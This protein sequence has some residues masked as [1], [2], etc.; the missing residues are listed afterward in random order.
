MEFTEVCMRRRSVRSYENR[1]I[2]R[3]DLLD[4]LEAGMYAPSAVNLQ[5]WHFVVLQSEEHLLRLRELMTSVSRSMQ[6]DL[7]ARFQ[8]RPEI[9]ADATSFLCNLGG[10]PVAILVFPYKPKYVKSGSSVTQSISAAIENML[11]AATD[12]GLG[13]CWLTAPV[14][15]GY[16]ETFRAAFAPDKG[17]LTALITLSYPAEIPP[18]PA[19]KS[20]HYVIL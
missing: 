15:A 1:A 20:G 4:I 7:Q 8:N 17:P 6:P 5:P 13:S 10:A 3:D 2:S 18:A 9:A 14:E 12:K 19:R 11:L 16:A